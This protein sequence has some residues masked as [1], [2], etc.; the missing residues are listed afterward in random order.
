MFDLNAWVKGIVGDVPD[1][2]LKTIVLRGVLASDDVLKADERPPPEKRIWQPQL[3]FPDNKKSSSKMALFEAALES[4]AKPGERGHLLQVVYGEGGDGG[5]S[6]A[7]SIME[8]H[9]VPIMF[10]EASTRLFRYFTDDAIHFVALQGTLTEAIE[11]L[12]A[13]DESLKKRIVVV[14]DD[15]ALIKTSRRAVTH[16]MGPHVTEDQAAADAELRKANGFDKLH[17][18]IIGGSHPRDPPIVGYSKGVVQSACKG[19][20]VVGAGPN[21]RPDTQPGPVAKKQRL[22]RE[23][24]DPM[25]DDPKYGKLDLK[26]KRLLCHIYDAVGEANKEFGK[27]DLKDIPSYTVYTTNKMT[28]VF[29]AIV[30]SIVPRGYVVNVRQGRYVLT[31]EGVKTA[32]EL[33]NTLGVGGL[34]SPT[35]PC[36]GADV[37]A[38]SEEPVLA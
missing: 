7:R 18:Y 27:K 25:V 32:R 24:I 3:P 8:V 30:K 9:P 22:V 10:V 33:K 16:Y 11:S 6:V 34:P 4:A 37:A 21:T 12:D 38:C 36:G 19:V 20:P 2:V 28:V 26:W 1:H 23:Q 31:E 35:T 15:P 17:H 5:D 14:T 29:S 13:A